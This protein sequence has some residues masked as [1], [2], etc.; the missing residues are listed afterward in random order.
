MKKIRKKKTF[1]AIEINITVYFLKYF[2][3][4]YTPKMSKIASFV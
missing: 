2:K 4:H 1:G 3:S